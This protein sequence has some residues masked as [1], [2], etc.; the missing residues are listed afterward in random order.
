MSDFARS[1]YVRLVALLNANPETWVHYKP[2]ALLFRPHRRLS[3]RGG[4]LLEALGEI[5]R[6]CHE[7][8]LPAIPA[9]VVRVTDGR[10]GDG[11]FQ[12]AFPGIL[13]EKERQRLWRA[14]VS[15]VRQI[16]YPEVAV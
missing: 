16:G 6:W 3:W 9:I 12:V 10:P 1:V 7:H 8:N 11:F 15:R 5:V 4:P 14:E 2:L 13:D